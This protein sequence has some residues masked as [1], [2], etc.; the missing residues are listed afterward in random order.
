MAM[1]C[2]SPG[3]VAVPRSVQHRPR[4]AAI[5]KEAH[6]GAQRTSF[7]KLQR[8][9]A[10]KAKQALKREKRQS[11]EPEPGDEVEEQ[12]TPLGEGGELSA[13]ELLTQIA[14]IHKQLDDKTISF[15]EFEELKTDLMARL[16]ID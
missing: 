5:G 4:R 9:R 14:L 12:V 13:D 6:M 1:A 11:G 16:P 3:A 8:D 2:P 10:K 7:E 15:E